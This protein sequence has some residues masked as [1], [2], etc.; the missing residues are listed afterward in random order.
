[1]T[2]EDR[3]WIE[4]LI[5]QAM[6]RLFWIALFCITATWGMVLFALSVIGA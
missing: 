4:R 1:M 5:D 6:H 2:H 3:E